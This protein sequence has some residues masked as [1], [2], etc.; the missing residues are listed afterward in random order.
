MFS[1]SGFRFGG[2]NMRPNMM[3]RWLAALGCVLALAACDPAS[4]LKDP[5]VDLGNF[6]LGHNVAVVVQD[7][8][9]LPGSRIVTVAEWKDA[10]TG[11]IDARFG[12]YDG[13]KQY[14]IS[15]SVRGYNLSRFDVPGVPGPK[16]LVDLHAR[17]W[18]DALGKMLHDAPQEIQILVAFNEIG[19]QP[20]KREQLD[21]L[22]ARAAKEVETWLLQ[23]PEWFEGG[24]P[25][26][27]EPVMPI[28]TELVPVPRPASVAQG[29]GPA[30]CPTDACLFAPSP[31]TSAR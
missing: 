4:D 2:S 7:V 21:Y 15:L 13:F 17:I 29:A 6:R 30:V 9:I 28:S 20:N 27:P 31:L 5:P 22:A 25:P 26:L 14:H 19:V 11:A 23:H 16:T 18:D 24:A 10:L 3:R 12:R 8:T 1:E